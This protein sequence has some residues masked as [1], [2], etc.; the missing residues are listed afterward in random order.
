MQ[1]SDNMSTMVASKQADLRA[2]PLEMLTQV[3]AI[4]EGGHAH[5]VSEPQD[6]ATPVVRF[7]SAI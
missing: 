4:F 6:A 5:V 7:G 2:V 3:T 1:T